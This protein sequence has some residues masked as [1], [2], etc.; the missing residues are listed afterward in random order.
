MAD[1]SFFY[2]GPGGDPFIGRVDKLLEIVVGEHVGGHALAP[3]RYLGV[4][5]GGLLSVRPS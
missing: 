5:H 4:P 3:A 1:P 2:P